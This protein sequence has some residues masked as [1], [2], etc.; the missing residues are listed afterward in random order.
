MI[1]PVKTR[2]TIMAV[3]TLFIMP[4]LSKHF[5]VEYT[6]GGEKSQSEETIGVI[7]IT[8]Y[9]GYEGTT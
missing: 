5:I 4:P 3:T 9:T 7:T 2:K 1:T 6:P 8:A